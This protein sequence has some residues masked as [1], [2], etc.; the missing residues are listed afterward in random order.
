MLCVCALIARATPAREKDDSARAGSRLE[1]KILLAEGDRS[2][3]GAVLIAVHLETGKTFTAPPSTSE[4]RYSLQ[5]LP[6]GYYQ[7]AVDADGVLHAARGVVNL[8]PGRSESLS[9]R[10]LPRGEAHEPWSAGPAGGV[11]LPG[12]DRAA[13]GTAEIL[14]L[15]ER[16]PFLKTPLGLATI[17][18]GS[19][20]FLLLL[21]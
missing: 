4:G 20:L 14:G 2:V 15:T 6:F 21:T 8:T 7:F 9:F 5:K 19:V 3:S 1:G 18:G 16:V 13:T 10:L 11:V 12:L 17:V